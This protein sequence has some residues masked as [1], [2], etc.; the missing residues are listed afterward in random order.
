MPGQGIGIYISTMTPGWNL[1]HCSM[2]RVLKLQVAVPSLNHCIIYSLE[3]IKRDPWY[4]KPK[5][6]PEHKLGVI[7][8]SKIPFRY[9][10]SSK[11]LNINHE[12]PF[13]FKMLFKMVYRCMQTNFHSLEHISGAYRSFQDINIMLFKE[14]LSLYLT[15]INE[16]FLL[17]LS[18][19]LDYFKLWLFLI[20]YIGNLIVIY[21]TFP[22]NN[23]V[24]MCEI[25]L[26]I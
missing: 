12:L 19:L 10:C 9:W 7:Q 11:L 26:K 16:G 20:M 25:A 14:A 4:K 2:N 13:T 24:F 3:H 6:S 23:V 15:E 8:K 17:W 5:M 1:R 18:Y 22:N 21:I